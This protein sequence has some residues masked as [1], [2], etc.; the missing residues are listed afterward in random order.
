MMHPSLPAEKAILA[1]YGQRKGADS[2]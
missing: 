1:F 2:N